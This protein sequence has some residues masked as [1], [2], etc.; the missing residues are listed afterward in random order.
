VRRR[1]VAAAL[2][3]LLAVLLLHLWLAARVAASRIGAG[4]ADRPPARIEMAFVQVLAPTAP[5][6]VAALAAP[7][8]RARPEVA[9]PAAEPA[10]ASEAAASAAPPAP[11]A[12]DPA[13]ELAPALAD[14]APPVAEVP[15]AP[16]S[17]AVPAFEWPPSTRLSYTLTGNYRG[18]IDGQA[19]V[20]WVRSGERYQVHLDV[21]IGPSFAPLITRSM[22]SD[23]ELG[24]DG[25][26]PR[27][28]DE[29]TRIV[30]RDAR[31][32]TILFEPQEVLLANG[33]RMPRPPGVQDSVSQFVQLSWRF[34]LQP[35]LLTVGRVLEVPLALPRRVE[36]WVYDVL[37]SE[38]LDT[39]AGPVAAVRVR[40]RR[41][42]KAGGDLVPEMWFAPTLQYLP[43]RIV[44]RL[45]AETWLDLL[46][47]RLP[48]QALPGAA[49]QPGSA[50]RR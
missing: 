37:A 10:S 23:G 22:S 3:L 32:A 26:Q 35:E 47:N 48:Q 36:T 33:R 17:A 19:Q 34:T 2:A 46:I 21:T 30:L 13:T 14:A 43:V 12:S 11:A 41:E 6:A 49:D 4:A 7:R 29:V 8:R 25:L 20:E 45:D 31:P 16:A 38:T 44:L 42:A 27:R 50:P 5:A 39:P 18:P 9:V 1:R 40:S 24:P 15:Q 28:Y